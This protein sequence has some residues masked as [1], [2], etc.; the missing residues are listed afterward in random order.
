M[1]W[2][3]PRHEQTGASRGHTRRD[4]VSV[5]PST[6]GSIFLPGESLVETRNIHHSPSVLRVD[7]HV[8]VSTCMPE[9]ALSFFIFLCAIL[10]YHLTDFDTSNMHSSC[11]NGSTFFLWYKQSEVICNKDRG[12]GSDGKI[13]KCYNSGF[14][15]VDY[16][17]R[18]FRI[19][20]TAHYRGQIER[21]WFVLVEIG[22]FLHLFLLHPAM[23]SIFEVG[24]GQLNCMILV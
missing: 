2:C 24:Q 14:E 13:A 23:H 15:L 4:I 21:R 9:Y 16:R 20:P 17:M 3:R 7:K 5:E 10:K 6:M 1:L 19:P 18:H 12:E 22:A 11:Y 8:S